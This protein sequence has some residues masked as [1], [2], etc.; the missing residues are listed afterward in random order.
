MGAIFIVP[1]SI[2]IKVILYNLRNID[3]HAAAEEQIHFFYQTENV[4][5]SQDR[6]VSLHTI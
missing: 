4:L 6:R 1:T 5:R 3:I 2:I